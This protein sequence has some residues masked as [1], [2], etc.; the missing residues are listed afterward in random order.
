MNCLV[1][2][3]GSIGRRRAKILLA[4]GHRVML[5]DSV[6]DNAA[7]AYQALKGTGHAP[8]AAHIGGNLATGWGDGDGPAYDVALICTPPDS[9]RP[10]Q[11]QRCLEL[12][13][14]GLFVEKPLA[15]GPSDVEEIR[16]TLERL[17]KNGEDITTMGA[18]NLRF[19]GGVSGLRKIPQPWRLARFTMR[20]AAKHWS[21]THRPI[22]LIM[23]SIH[24]LDLAVD[25]QGPIESIRGYSELDAAEVS[26]HHEGGGLSHIFLD[27]TTSPPAREVQVLR[28]GDYDSLMLRTDDTMYER[29]MAHFMECVEKGVQTCN[30]LRAAAEVCARALEVA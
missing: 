20:Q 6:T 25:L 17:Y 30:P 21:P 14:K 15:L 24:E 26:V 11:I 9:G 12:G 13:V 27:R 8:V 16:Y 5:Y 19:C 29:E 3:C 4:Q 18:C 28:A 23:D 2:G 1:I 22:S 7:L 10:E